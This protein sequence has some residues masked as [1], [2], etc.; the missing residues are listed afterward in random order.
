MPTLEDQVQLPGAFT[1]DFTVVRALLP[2][3]R[4]YE[5]AVKSLQPYRLIREPAEGARNGMREIAERSRQRK[6]PALIYVN[7]R[8]EGFAPG[9]IEAV[10]Y[11]ISTK[12]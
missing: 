6:T 1:A 7:N 4:R 2:K 9:T 12:G 11:Q 3:G 10:A 5:D 8:L